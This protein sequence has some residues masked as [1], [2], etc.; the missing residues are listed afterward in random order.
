M[1][2]FKR[3]FISLFCVFL[4][5]PNFNMNNVY[6]GS[7]LTTQT[8]PELAINTGYAEKKNI[9]IT[10][11]SEPI[12]LTKLQK[13]KLNSTHT[14]S[15]PWE[16][17]NTISFLTCEVL[18]SSGK[19][20]ASKALSGSHSSSYTEFLDCSNISSGYGHIRIT[21]TA[22]H[23]P[24]DSGTRVVFS[25]PTIYMTAKPVITGVLANGNSCVQNDGNLT[26]QKMS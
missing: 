6:A 3:I 10:K 16:S 25:A 26:T 1:K 20:V 4:L 7:E 18:D 9:T 24:G 17:V 23:G 21:A 8:L 19:V 11:T 15:F 2:Y 14:Y 5:I 12:S 13:I 22:P